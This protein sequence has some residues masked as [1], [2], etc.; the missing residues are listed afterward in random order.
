[1]QYFIKGNFPFSIQ[2]L[3]SDGLQHYQPEY[4]IIWVRKG[5]GWHVIDQVKHPVTDNTVFFAA[6]G[7]QHQLI[8]HPESEGYIVSFNE[9]FI[10]YCEDD[11][12]A[13][14]STKLLNQFTQCAGIPVTDEVEE[15][16]TGM[17]HES[18]NLFLYLQVFL[19]YITRH[20]NNIPK[21]ADVDN[22]TVV[23]KF[24]SLLEAHFKEIKTVAGYAQILC[25]SPSYLNEIV[26]R[27]SGFSAGHHIR[28]RIIHEAKRRA[29]R[30]DASMKEIAWHLGFSDIAH[31]S[32]LF[33]KITGK[34]FSNFRK[35][36]SISLF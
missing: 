17:I 6:T 29:I 11:F 15:M 16:I 2:L 28:M 20:F 9:A 1:M 14:C 25:I 34:S 12:E 24:I 22:H 31:F 23:R 36:L 18:S 13:V 26:K 27:E 4:E 21:V 19:I 33:K 10:S 3:H 8:I 5:T 32:K 7:Q 30:S 35:Q